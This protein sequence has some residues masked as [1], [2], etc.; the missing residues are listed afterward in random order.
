MR[1]VTREHWCLEGW[2][3]RSQLAG[4]VPLAT[5]IIKSLTLAFFSQG[6]EWEEPSFCLHGICW[7]SLCVETK[8]AKSYL[9]HLWTISCHACCDYANFVG[10]AAY[11]GHGRSGYARG[12]TARS[13]CQRSKGRRSA[14]SKKKIPKEIARKKATYLTQD[15]TWT[16]FRCQ[17]IKKFTSTPTRIFQPSIARKCKIQITCRFWLRPSCL[18]VFSTS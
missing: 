10:N 2:D 17:T 8:L 16:P 15:S 4:A 7:Q 11:N 5:S 12:C 3:F 9:E 1:L 6:Q 13:K 18:A 14:S